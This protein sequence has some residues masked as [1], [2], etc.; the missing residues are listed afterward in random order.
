ME[1][2]EGVKKCYAL[3]ISGGGAKAAYQ[4]GVVHSLVHQASE[5]EASLYEW[6]VVSGVS[7]GSLNV[8]F[9]SLFAKGEEKKVSSMAK[10]RIF[11]LKTSN[12]FRSWSNGGILAGITTQRG[13]YDDQPLLNF[14][15]EAIEGVGATEIQRKL[16]IS[17]A[18]ISTGAYH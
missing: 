18:D 5:E 1:E 6:D 8:G 4:L 17:T 12:I 10:E 3:A 16:I 13:L 7:A 11:S 2:A 9:L 15:E 14:L